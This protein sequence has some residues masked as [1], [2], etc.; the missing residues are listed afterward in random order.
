MNRIGRLL[1]IAGLLFGCNLGPEYRATVERP[2]AFGNEAA[3]TGVAA[4]ERESGSSWDLCSGVLI[5]PDVV[6]TA[7]HCATGQSGPIDCTS[8]PLAPAV[9]PGSLRVSFV[10]DLSGAADPTWEFFEVAEIDLLVPLGTSLFDIDLSLPYLTDPVPPSVAT[11]LAVSGAPVSAGDPVQLAGYGAGHPSGTGQRVR[12]V[13]DE[14]EIVCRGASC[15]DTGLSGWG[16]EPIVA[17]FVGTHEFITEA[18]ACP[19]DSGG[20]ALS[21]GE[22]VGILSRGFADCTAPVFGMAWDSIA[23]AVRMHSTEAGTEPP[24]WTTPPPLASGGQGGEGNDVKHEG[25]AGGG[26]MGGAATQPTEQ[27]TNASGCSMVTSHARSSLGPLTPLLLVLAALRRRRLTTLMA[28]LA[29]MTLLGCTREV[30]DTE[31]RTFA[32]TCEKNECSLDPTPPAGATPWEAVHPGRVLLACPEGAGDGRD[33]RP[34]ACDSDAPCTRLGGEQMECV[35]G[36]CQNKTNDVSDEDRLALCL[37]GTGA[38]QDAPEQRSRM[39]MAMS[40]RPPCSV[41]DACRQLED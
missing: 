11:P 6:L 20:P 4:I 18:G 21:R 22:V 33:C 27:P 34:L 19:G 16:G 28:A 35:G 32:I 24:A 31:A 25:E 30:Q 38:W 41:P 5:A 7:G 37:A 23:S 1:L 12:R 36:L 2:V 10:A 8:A 15:P 13:S 40:C 3:P 29:A 9:P 14:V 17:P 39:A 26:G